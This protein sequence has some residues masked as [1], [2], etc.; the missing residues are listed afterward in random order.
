MW[1]MPRAIVGRRLSG[2]WPS[3]PRRPLTSRSL[4]FDVHPIDA[5]P[6][7]DAVHAFAYRYGAGW[8]CSMS[9]GA[10][11][12][13]RTAIGYGATHLLVEDGWPTRPG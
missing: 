9:G 1:A 2:P 8:R 7:A 5:R 13:D 10:S 11:A 6:R 12:Q 3:R 4:A